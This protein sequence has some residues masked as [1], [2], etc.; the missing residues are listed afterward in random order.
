M[1]LEGYTT[2]VVGSYSVPYWYEAL[3]KQVESGAFMPEDM[4][5][6]QYRAS[7]AAILDQETAGVD[8][9]TG[10]E[11]HRRTNNRHAPPNAMLNHFWSRIPGFSQETRPKSITAQDPEVT[12]PAAVLKDRIS[13]ADL[14]LVDE[15]RMVSTY[16]RRDVKI[17]MTGPHMLAKVCHDEYY[18]DLTQVMQ[19]LAAVINR[20]FQELQAAGCA[21]VQLDE[22]LFAAVDRSEVEAAVAAVNQCFEGID[23]Y[24]WVHICHGNYSVSEAFDEGEQV[25][26]RYFD[27]FGE[28]PADLIARIDCDALM[29]EYDVVDL[30]RDVLRDQQVAIGAAD[31]QE[32]S[33]ESPEQIIERVEAQRWLSPEQ[34]LLTTTCGLNHLPREVCYRK[35]AAL[36]EARDRMRGKR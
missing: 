33:V 30:Y 22:P 15:F 24:R 16:A 17:T 21:H 10:G 29:L 36:C 28:Q 31:V 4:I 18:G 12:H 5:D 27:D 2:A 26:H 1:V 25:G 6:A 32:K 9:V 35:L 8:V 14:G 34:T 20:N 13:Y 19:D 3:E 11:M 23:A 7:Q